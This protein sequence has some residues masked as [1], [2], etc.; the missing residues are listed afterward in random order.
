MAVG[1][2]RADAGLARGLGEGEARRALL[3]NQVECGLDQRL[4]QVAVMIAAPPAAAVPV[5]AHGPV[6]AQTGAAAHTRA[7][8]VLRRLP[9]ISCR[10]NQKAWRR[11]P[12][13]ATRKTGR[14]A[15]AVHAPAPRAPRPPTGRMNSTNANSDTASPRASGAIWVAWSAACCAALE[16]EA[17]RAT[18][19]GASQS[20][21]VQ[22][23]HQ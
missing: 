21:G 23:K 17:E 12:A 11:A 16:A 7:A 5:P 8:F 15:V 10:R 20:Q 4:A 13:A 3:G 6:L 18:A 22:A 19:G 2:G 9:R 14:A 1:R